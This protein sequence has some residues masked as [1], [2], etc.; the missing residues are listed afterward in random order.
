MVRYGGGDQLRYSWHGDLR[1]HLHE[2]GRL[3][4]D[5]G[6]AVDVIIGRAFLEVVNGRPIDPETASAT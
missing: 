5:D 2:R 4:L 6:S 1:G 3:V